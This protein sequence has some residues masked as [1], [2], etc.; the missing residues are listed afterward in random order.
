MKCKDIERLVIDSSEEDLSAEELSEIEE[1]VLHCAKCA[2]FQDDLK[3]IRICLKEMTIRVP[4]AALIRRT[5]SI[6][7]TKMRTLHAADR[8]TAGQ[9]NLISI[10]KYMW[11]ALISLIVFTIIWMLP[12]LKDI[13]LNQTLSFETVVVFTIMIQNAVMLFFAPLLIRRYRLKNQGFGPL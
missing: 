3:K 4:S 5:Q 7:H 11:V 12:L 10:P 6:C 9:T 2:R 8:R 1:H 13:R